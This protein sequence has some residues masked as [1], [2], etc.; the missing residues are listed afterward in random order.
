[1]TA[2]GTKKIVVTTLRFLISFG[3][4]GII[5]Y[6]FREQLPAVVDHLRG[7]D[8]GYFLLALV[9]FFAGHIFVAQRLRAVLEVHQ[10]GLT[11][12]Q[13]YYVNL[14]GLFFNNVLPSSVGG[15]MVKAYYIY[16]GTNG[17]VAAFSA[18]VVDRLFGLVVMVAIGLTALALF[19]RG[20]ASP[21]IV[22]SVAG[23]A[24]VVVLVMVAIFNTRIVN[25]LC[26]ARI[27]L[28]PMVLAEK[29]KEMYQAMY[30]YRGQ[31]GIILRCLGLTALGQISFIIVNYLLARSLSLDI[32]LTF[33]FFFVPIILILTMA[34]S[35]NG[36]GVREATYL[37]YL[38]GFATSDRALALSV[39][40]T[41]FMIFTGII[42]GLAYAVKGGLEKESGEGRGARDEGRGTRDEG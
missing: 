13:V 10:A 36:I 11:L 23:L 14:V 17:K 26:R 12:W 15:E 41:F 32:P 7:A 27:P 29:L 39:F 24:L 1:M 18:V 30:H 25:G 4:I 2:A 28:M 22:G 3:A 31:H 38:A 35:V 5:L 8:P 40:T 6:L 34:P 16:R 19:G 33:F 21:R 42:G 9:V 20:L 37:F